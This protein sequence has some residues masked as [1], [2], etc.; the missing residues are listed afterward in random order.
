VFQEGMVEVEINEETQ[1]VITSQSISVLSVT[2]WVTLR[3]IILDVKLIP[4]SI[5]VRFDC[6]F[7]LDLNKGTNQTNLIDLD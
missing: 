1:R 6:L 5:N 4:K 2:R 3:G 7:G